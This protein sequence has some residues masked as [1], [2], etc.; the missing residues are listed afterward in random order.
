MLCLMLTHFFFLFLVFSVTLSNI[1]QKWDKGDGRDWGRLGYRILQALSENLQIKKERKKETH[2]F[3][4]DLG[5]G[6]G[7]EW[8]WDEK[9]EDGDSTFGGRWW[10]WWLA[11]WYLRIRNKRR[12]DIWNWYAAVSCLMAERVFSCFNMVT[13][14]ASLFLNN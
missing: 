9:G 5:M 4:F 1:L 13:H 7:T 8:G 2:W 3:S 12:L 11:A 10:C 14:W 6:A